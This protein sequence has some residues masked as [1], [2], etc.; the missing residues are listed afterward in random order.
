MELLQANTQ[1]NNRPDDERFGSLAEM[2]G[3]CCDHFETARVATVNLSDMRAEPAQ[4]EAGALELGRGADLAIVGPAGVPARLNSWSFNQLAQ[5]VGA[6]GGYL[7]RLPARIAA[8]AIT[9]GLRQLGDDGASAQALFQQSAGGLVSRAFTSDRYSRIW[10]H[11]IIGRLLDLEAAGAWRVP[12]ARPA[13]HDQRGARPATAADILPNQSEFG[14]SI[15]IGDMIAPAGLY[16]SAHDCFAFMVNENNRI[17]DG[18]DCGLARGFFVS[19]SEVGAAAFK[20]TRFMYRHVCGNHIVWGASDVQELRIVHTGKAD[21]RFIQELRGEL[22]KYADSSASEDEA[23]IVSAKRFSLGDSRDQVLDL[24][25]KRAILPKRDLV[26]A[27][28]QAER[29]DTGAGSP[30]SAWGFAQGLTSYSQTLPYA[31]KRMELDRAAGK[32]LS[33]A[34]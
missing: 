22:V 16:A 25:F 1:W 4:L 19:N 14:L 31:D 26:A 9:H 34:F 12:P 29:D 5:R 7:Q 18:S 32:V 28:D 21:S 30:S 20:I 10:N 6:P 15:N 17:A 33:M 2:H 11:E 24:L 3:A 8:D 23:R 27:Y 13:R